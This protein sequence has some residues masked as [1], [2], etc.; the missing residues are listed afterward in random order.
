MFVDKELY[1]RMNICI[2]KLLNQIDLEISD[3]EL[4]TFR[5]FQ[6]TLLCTSFRYFQKTLLCTSFRY[7]QITLLCTSF[8]YFQITRLCITFRYFQITLLC[9]TFR[10]FQITL[11]CTT[12]R[13]FQIKIESFETQMLQYRQQIEMLENHLASLHQPNRITPEG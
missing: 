13:Y 4:F 9:T 3:F 12:F 1:S 5:Y 2:I 6:I 8:R 7:F 11:L 10:Y